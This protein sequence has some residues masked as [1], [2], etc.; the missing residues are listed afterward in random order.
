MRSAAGATTGGESGGSRVRVILA[1]PRGF[2]AGVTRAIAAVERA[3][4][5]YG[6]PAHVWHEIVHDRAVGEDLRAKG[7]VFVDETDDV[8]PGGIVTFSAHGVARR[9]V[10][11]AEAAGSRSSTPPGR[12]SARST[13]RGGGTPGKAAR[14]C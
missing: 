14:S 6:P 10:E 8:P 9:V 3:L 11:Q 13:S 4:E 1:Q 7:A 5:L 12:S 2:C